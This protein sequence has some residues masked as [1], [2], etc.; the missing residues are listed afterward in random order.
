MR[1]YA[2]SI[3]LCLALGLLGGC[4]TAPDS[5]FDQMPAPMASA[6]TAEEDGG[7]PE[8]IPG[9][10]TE[11]LFDDGWLADIDDS[12]LTAMVHEAVAQNYDLQATAAR[13]QI[14]QAEAAI[15]NADSWPQLNGSFGGSRR[16][17]NFGADG[18]GAIPSATF[19]TY[20]VGLDLSWEL[21]I[22]G[23][24]RDG[25]SAAIADAQAAAATLQGARLSLAANTAKAWFD[26]IEAELQV[27]LAEETFDSFND[28][29]NVIQ[30]RF[31]RGVSPALDLRLAR[32]QASSAAANLEFR[33]QARDA[34]VRNLEVLMGRYPAN[35]IELATDLPTITAPVPAGLPSELLERRPDL[36]V[37]ERNLAASGKRV[38]EA[39]KQ[40]LPSIS[41]TGS[42]GYSSSQLGELF[43]GGF[44]VWSLAGNAVQP[45]FQARRISANIERT[46]AVAIER[47]A[48]YGQTALDAFAEV[49]IALESEAYLVRR[50]EA[51]RDAAEENTGAEDTAWARYQRGLTDIITVLESQRRAF[52][53]KV[54]LLD[55]RNERLQNRINLYLALGGDFGKE[56]VP[57]AEIT[58]PTGPQAYPNEPVPAATPHL[59]SVE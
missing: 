22:W 20:S 9:A 43:A 30:G 33:L 41:L 25:T 51:L 2:H 15:T 24:V 16:R 44:S 45:I 28:T 12:T 58:W 17:Q 37:A 57:E 42:Y 11:P 47:L 34:T 7:A 31:E 3:P 52:T 10:A 40:M 38:S 8:A 14:A 49:E 54:D 55:S 46:K 23:R 5:E 6:W 29:A 13:L 27:Q 53:S 19:N 21:D 50:V 26:A 36:I 48:A 59:S 4:A 56:T 32:A 1:P 18:L 39:K 35:E